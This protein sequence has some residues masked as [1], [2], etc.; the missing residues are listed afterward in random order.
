VVE[1][2]STSHQALQKVGEVILRRNWTKA[3]CGGGSMFT[4]GILNSGDG[5]FTGLVK[6][7]SSSSLGKLY[8]TQGKPVAGLV[9]VE[10]S[11]VQR[12]IVT[13]SGRRWRAAM[14]PAPVKLR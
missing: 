8:G 1:L 3:S 14:L 6:Q 5:D 13:G 9:R 7:S 10:R 12:F 2:D 11:W 4:G